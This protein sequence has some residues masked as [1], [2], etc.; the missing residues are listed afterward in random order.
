MYET[1]KKGDSNK[2]CLNT[3]KTGQKCENVNILRRTASEFFCLFK[4]LQRS[5]NRFSIKFR[6]FVRSERKNFQRR[7]L[8]LCMVNDQYKRASTTFFDEKNFLKNTICVFLNC[9]FGR[10]LF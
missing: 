3:F 2:I 10:E 1:V 8:E 5:R 4:Y 7:F 6:E 9:L